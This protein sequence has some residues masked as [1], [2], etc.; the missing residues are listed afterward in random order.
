MTWRRDKSESVIILPTARGRGWRG[1]LGAS[2]LKQS[3]AVKDYDTYS[4]SEDV[5]KGD[6]RTSVEVNHLDDLRHIRLPLC[7]AQWTYKLTLRH[8]ISGTHAR[9]YGLETETRA[10]WASWHIVCRQENVR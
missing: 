1:R 8:Y 7:C 5:I 6:D 4:T 2:Y 3:K 9:A 10:S